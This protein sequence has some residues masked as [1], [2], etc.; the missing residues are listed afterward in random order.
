[1]IRLVRW[2][3]GLMLHEF[4]GGGGGAADRQIRLQQEEE[5]KKAELRKRVGYLFGEGPDTEQVAVGKTRSPVTVEA[6]EGERVPPLRNRIQ[7]FEDKPVYETRSTGAPEARAQFAKEETDLAGALRGHY[8]DE[9]ADQYAKAE[10]A[11][12]FGAANTG[13]VGGSVYSDAQAELEKDRRLG[14][15]RTEEATQRAI[16]NLR[17]S[18]DEAKL[19]AIG[20]VSSGA[21]DSAVQAAR[22]GIQASLD[23]VRTAQKEQ[24]FSDLFG[25]IALAK[26]GSDARDRNAEALALFAGL[27]RNGLGAGPGTSGPRIFETG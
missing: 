2:W 19:R 1:M 4:G 11:T 23:N 10:R 27:R 9:L 12:R 21:G 14:G 22:S 17:A 26:R 3:L 6:T 18:R 24:L 15:V 13:N 20:L 8:G 25:D 5:A 16:A 7:A